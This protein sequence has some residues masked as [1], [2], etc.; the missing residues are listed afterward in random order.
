M[1]LVQARQRVASTALASL[2]AGQVFDGGGLFFLDQHLGHDV[3]DGR[4]NDERDHEVDEVA[5]ADGDL[6][7]RI[8]ADGGLQDPLDLAEVDATQDVADRRHD[9]VVD[10]RVHDAAERGADDHADR[11][12]QGIRLEQ[13][14]LESGHSGRLLHVHKG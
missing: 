5:E 7:R 3:D 2:Q 13:E 6:G 10:Q 9:D 1:S 11:Q 8:A 14:L 4:D 12:G